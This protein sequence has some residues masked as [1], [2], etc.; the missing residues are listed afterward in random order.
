MTPADI[1][2]SSTLVTRSLLTRI[3]LRLLLQLHYR[4]HLPLPLHPA[5]SAAA[6][7]PPATPR[8][9]PALIPPPSSPRSPPIAS[10]TAARP[11]IPFSTAQYPF[12][13]AYTALSTTSLSALPSAHTFAGRRL[14]SRSPSSPN[15]SPSYS[16]TFHS[17]TMRS[18]SS[19]FSTSSSSS[20]SLPSSWSSRDVQQYLSHYPSQRDNPSLNDNFRFYSNSIPSRPDGALIDTIHTQW[21]RQYPLLESHHGYIQ[22]L[23]PLREEGMNSRIHPLQPHEVDAMKASAECRERLLKSYRLILDFWGFRL[24]R[25]EGERMRIGEGEEGGEGGVVVVSEERVDNLVRSSHNWLR[26]SRVLKSLGELGQERMK[27]GFVLRLWVVATGEA[28]SKGMRRSWEDYWS[29][30]L[31]E[32]GDRKLAQEVREGKWDVR[33]TRVYAQLLRRRA[34]ERKREKE[35]GSAQEDDDEERAE[36]KEEEKNGTKGENGQTEDGEAG[37]VEESDAGELTKR[38]KRNVDDSHGNARVVDGDSETGAAMQALQ[39]EK[40]DEV[41]QERSAAED[42][43]EVDGGKDEL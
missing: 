14:R 35:G 11:V 3:F 1:I 15:P 12:L 10:L 23:F 25:E 43:A 22:W 34:E 29:A 37:D 13:P 32:E 42:T 6:H 21:A 9:L 17:P 36:R 4:P 33:D 18:L 8:D 39:E 19:Y 16:S 24:M 20:S 26:V 40:K 5:L 2:S 38:R 41:K 28:G 30:V 31:R 7:F 27:L